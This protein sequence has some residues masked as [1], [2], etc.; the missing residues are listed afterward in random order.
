MSVTDD[1]RHIMCSVLYVYVK[2]E[3]QMYV[4]F[5][6]QVVGLKLYKPIQYTML[7]FA[8]ITVTLLAN[9]LINTG[10]TYTF[11][12]PVYHGSV[13][14]KLHWIKESEYF[15]VLVFSVVLRFVLQTFSENMFGMPEV[16]LFRK[17]YTSENQKL[18]F[19]RIEL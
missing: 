9:F 17:C 1:F 19:L 14:H 5:L 7:Y 16:T 6:V 12:S 8:G 3:V 11:T 15:N 10:Y 18:D 4:N 13:M 2:I